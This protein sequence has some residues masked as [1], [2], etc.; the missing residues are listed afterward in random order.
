MPNASAMPN[1]THNRTAPPVTQGEGGVAVD[2]GVGVG[3]GDVAGGEGA[4]EAS[5]VEG[6]MRS[7]RAPRNHSAAA[8]P[9]TTSSASA[10]HRRGG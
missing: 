5:E 8:A 3:K 4:D 9:S 2:G 6:L 7:G 10:S 1:M